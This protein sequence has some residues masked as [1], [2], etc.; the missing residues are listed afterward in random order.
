MDP[1][2]FQSFLMGG[3]ECSTHRRADGRRLDLIA[4]T[5]HDR[6]ALQ[7]YTRLAEFGIRT[8]RD[9]LRWHLIEKIPGR[10]DFSSVFGQLDTAETAGVQV[11]WDLFHYG[12]PDHLDMF[13]PEFPAR[14]AD[15][16]IAFVR[17]YQSRTGRA[18]IVVPVNEISFL[19]W[20][21]GDIGHF[22][23][24]ATGRGN[25]LK[26][27]LVRAAIAAMSAMLAEADDTRFVASE[28][29]IYVRA[30]ASE[31]WHQEAAE[32]YRTAQYQTFDMLT[33]ELA[34]E[35]GGRPEY[36]DIIGLNYYPHN[37]WYYPDRQMIPLRDADY[38]PMS[39]ILAEI[40]E[41]YRRPLI[42]TET[43]TEGSERVPWIRY[44]AGECSTAISRGVDLRG[45]CIYPIV[46]YPGWA[47]ERHCPS[48]LWGY[49]DGNGR[50]PAYEPLRREIQVSFAQLAA[51][52]SAERCFA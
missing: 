27:Q 6:F 30:R 29:A 23:P 40:Y 11:V 47:D 10:Y 28:P 37:Q 5:G 21:A 32:R 7:D 33:G 12:Y 16:A 13:A 9:G 15:L 25:E 43:G 48:G 46:D 20:I 8:A 19:S 45:V 24:Y 3:F 42:I 34:P 2:P 17:F 1:R 49:C 22:H 14:L 38:R 26:R 41:R 51:A 18:P 4:A 44:V 50:R 39:E 52:A 31:P 36:L 35:L